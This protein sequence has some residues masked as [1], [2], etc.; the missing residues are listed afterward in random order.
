MIT[1]CP[2]CPH[3]ADSEDALLVHVA[4]AHLQDGAALER[5]AEMAG[6][7]PMLGVSLAETVRRLAAYRRTP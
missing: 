2:A 7:R 5:F 1:Q 4:D 3:V 6:I